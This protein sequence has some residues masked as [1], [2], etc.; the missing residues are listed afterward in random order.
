MENRTSYKGFTYSQDAYGYND[1][2]EMNRMVPGMSNAWNGY[3][4]YQVPST[5]TIEDMQIAGWFGY[6]GTAW[7]N[8]KPRVVT[9]NKIIERPQFVEVQTMH[10]QTLIEDLSVLN[11]VSVIRDISIL[12]NQS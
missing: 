4:I 8:L 2:L 11:N 5:F 3:I 9:Q 12:G 7:W 1:G 6:Y 10:V